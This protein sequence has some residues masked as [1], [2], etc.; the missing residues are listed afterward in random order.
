MKTHKYVIGFIVIFNSL[1]FGQN[2][3]PFGSNDAFIVKSHS[4]FHGMGQYIEYYYYTN[5]KVMKKVLINDTEFYEYRFGNSVYYLKN[6]DG[7]D[8][9]M[10]YNPVLDS[11]CLAIDFTVPVDS[12][13][14][15]HFYAN[16]NPFTLKCIGKDT[17]FLFGKL[18]TR[19]S[20]NGAQTGMST[21]VFV[22]GLG[23]YSKRY[24]EMYSSLD[25]A[26]I[27]AIIDSVFYNPIT[28]VITG[29]NISN[30]RA[31]DAFP[32][33]CVVNSQI[34]LW[35][36]IE[37]YCIDAY[38]YSGDSLILNRKCNI[39]PSSSLCFFNIKESELKAGDIIKYRVIYKDSSIFNN[40]REYP[41]TG[42][43]SLKVLPKTITGLS[44]NEDSEMKL[45]MEVYPNPFN[46]TSR[47]M[48]SVAESDMIRIEMYNIL[49]EKVM[50]IYEGY[51]Q[52]GSHSYD[53]NGRDLSGG[54]YILSLNNSKRTIS[55]KILLLK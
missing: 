18:R 34:S 48:V 9:L 30:E 49:G 26:Y 45:V 35:S 42:F 53:V 10:I 24:A 54:F 12:T 17:V 33:T 32:F 28:V 51:L 23:M 2:Y 44:G 52:A 22:E 4:L 14:Q 15:S 16:A 25:E 41:D 1:L 3:F 55:K 39:N 36:F 21:F 50:S 7:N 38:V 46:L 47:I 13:F 29:T 5:S 37:N 43:F 20:Y 27:S 31:I 19:A 8:S 40:Y 11:V 6:S